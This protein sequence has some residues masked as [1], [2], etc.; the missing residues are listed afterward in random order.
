MSA[1]KVFV[2]VNIYVGM[3]IRIFTIHKRFRDVK[4]KPSVIVFSKNNSFNF[5]MVPFKEKRSE[6]TVD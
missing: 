4:S 1:K 5:F 6:G 3:E 2:K